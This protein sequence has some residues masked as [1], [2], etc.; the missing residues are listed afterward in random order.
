MI[1]VLKSCSQPIPPAARLVISLL[2][3]AQIGA[4]VCQELANT[5]GDSD[6][7]YRL[8]VT[9]IDPSNT[10]VEGARVWSS[11]EREEHTVASGRDSTLVILSQCGMKPALIIK[12]GDICYQ[13]AAAGS[14]ATENSPIQSCVTNGGRDED[15]CQLVRQ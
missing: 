11:I 12:H 6:A 10:P 1:L 3:L 14:V 8:R 5:K 4:P 7:I 2:V 15:I 13:F 9:V